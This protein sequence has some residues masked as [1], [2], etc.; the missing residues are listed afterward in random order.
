M[1][2][3]RVRLTGTVEI[4]LPPE[5]AFTM[6]T[7]SGERTWAHGWDPRFPSPGADETE[8]GTVFQ[9]EHGGR[10]SVWIVARC[11]RGKS[12]SYV[13][14]TPGERCGLVTV[15]CEPSANGTR[16]TVSYDLTALSPGA[17]GKLGR[18][19]TSYPS[20]LGHWESSIAR[21]MSAERLQA[22]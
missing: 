21:A 9:T 16:A 20:F 22:D 11:D 3:L 5:Q 15:T 8:P 17:E 6:F 19:A 13:T 1:T 10:E 18:F 7:P 12:I 2:T 14:T 4:A